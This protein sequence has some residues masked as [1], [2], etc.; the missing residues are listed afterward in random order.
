M[1]A[2]VKIWR[3]RKLGGNDVFDGTIHTELS[4]AATLL[5]VVSPRYFLSQ[6]CREELD[7]FFQAAEQNGGVRLADKHRV[8]KVMKT[9]VPLEEHPAELREMLGYEFYAIDQGTKVARSVGPAT[10][11]AR[12]WLKSGTYA[13]IESCL[14][15]SRANTA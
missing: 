12:D 14:H 8:F 6:S 1:G 11:L 9:Y 5:T 3:D 13:L 10:R 7:G 4:R 15:Y 2:P